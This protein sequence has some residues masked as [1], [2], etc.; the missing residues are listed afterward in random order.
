MSDE[1]D[2][3]D[4]PDFVADMLDGLGRHMERQQRTA[5]VEIVDR[6]AEM[7]RELRRALDDLLA[8][9]GCNMDGSY[10]YESARRAEALLGCDE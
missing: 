10:V 4:T 5:A 2:K 9:Q 7:I 6:G 8:D 3:T 1:T